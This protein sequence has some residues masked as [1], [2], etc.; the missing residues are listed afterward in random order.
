MIQIDTKP[1]KHLQDLL[2]EGNDA[3]ILNYVKTEFP[4]VINNICES[5]SQI[6]NEY[7]QAR[8]EGL[9]RQVAYNEDMKRLNAILDESIKELN[10]NKE[11]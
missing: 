11:F 10:K 3:K 5:C 2:S 4:Q 8:L 6:E 7:K 9:N 1:L